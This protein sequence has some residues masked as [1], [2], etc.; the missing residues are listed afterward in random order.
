MSILNYENPQQKRTWLRKQSFL[1]VGIGVATG[2]LAIGSTLAANIN[3][4]SGA[5]VEFGQGVTLSTVCDENGFKVKPF[6]RFDKNRNIFVFSYLGITGVDLTPEGA[7]LTIDPS[8]RTQASDALSHRGEY[9]NAEGRWT[10]TCDNKALTFKLFTK[11][12]NYRYLTENNDID[13]QLFWAKSP[14]WNF[15]YNPSFRIWISNSEARTLGVA[16]SAIDFSTPWSNN[17]MLSY[18]W[19]LVAAIGSDSEI[20]LHIWGG[21]N[22][23]VPSDAVDVISV[24]S[25][26]RYPAMDSVE[27]SGYKSF[28]IWNNAWAQACGVEIPLATSYLA[29]GDSNNCG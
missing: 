10:K 15:Y 3:L 12:E 5:P 22:S 24:E 27:R 8:G 2:A 11:S 14:D 21:T 7:D 23:M 28:Y 19:P 17:W 13:S 26:E 18:F 16:N 29:S 25:E 4:N 1:I 20:R 9:K 6:S